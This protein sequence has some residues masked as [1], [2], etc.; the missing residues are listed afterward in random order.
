MKRGQA[1]APPVLEDLGDQIQI[2]PG[3]SGDVFLRAGNYNL[4]CS[5]AT[6]AEASEMFAR[7]A[8]IGA[9]IKV[10]RPQMPGDMNEG[11][12]Q[13]WLVERLPWTD[14]THTDVKVSE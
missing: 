11:Q 4:Q 6:A 2:Y 10:L 5:P 13:E 1:K 9:A 7:S 3:V 8:R 12:Q 14:S